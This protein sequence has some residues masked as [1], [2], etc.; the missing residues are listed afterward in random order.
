M[1]NIVIS[2]MLGT[3]GQ[4]VANL[5]KHDE[6]FKLLGGF[7][8]KGI[9]NTTNDLNKYHDVDVIIDFSHPRTLSQLLTYAKANQTALV[10]ATTGYTEEDFKLIKEV[11]KIVPIFYSENYSVGI[12]IVVHLLEQI[13][14]AI[15]DDYDIEIVEKHHRFKKDHPSGTAIKLYKA[16]NSNLSVKRNMTEDINEDGIKMH[17]LRLGNYVGEHTALFSNLDETIEVTHKAHT[18]EAFAKGAIQAAIFMSKQK[19]GL[20]QMDDLFGGF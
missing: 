12:N 4:V 6:R 3:M 13:A 14:K 15:N 10:L 16:I 20:Y 2:G 17:S 19:P 18:K 8:Q 5:V 11:S 7:D 1:I 9:G